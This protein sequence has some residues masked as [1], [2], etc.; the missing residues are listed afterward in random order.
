M[1]AV[2]AVERGGLLQKL[3]FRMDASPVPSEPTIGV[4]AAP[5]A[6]SRSTSSKPG[7]A[8]PLNE[9]SSTWTVK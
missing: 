4:E 2:I 5:A 3:A 9:T 6:N 7:F 8:A 1:F